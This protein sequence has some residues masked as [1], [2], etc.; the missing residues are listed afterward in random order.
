MSQVSPGD[1]GTRQ[2]PGSPARKGSPAKRPPAK[3]APKG[4]PVPGDGKGRPPTSGKTRNPT[5]G[6]NRPV[7]DQK[8]RPPTG[9]GRPPGSGGGKGRPPGAG[10]AKGRTPRPHM[11]ITAPP[12]RRF[13]P[14]TL[15]FASIGLVVVIILVFVVVKVT[16]G[17]NTPSKTAVLPPPTP[18][19]AQVVSDVTGVTAAVANT[20]GIGSG[21]TAPQ[22][23]KGQP[24]LTD[25]GKPELLFIG[26][27]FCPYCAAERWA[28]VMAMSRFGT[29]SG[30]METTSSPWDVYPDTATFTFRNATF[31]SQY[32][33]LVSVEHET[34]DNN[35]SGTRKLF[36]PL[37][38]A[39]S[40]LW[41]K[42]ST[43]FGE[44]TGYPFLDF[45][46]KVFV[47]GPSYVPDALAGLNQQEIAAKL[48]NTDDVV[49][50]RIVGTANYLTASIC[51]LTGNKPV[52]VCTAPGTHKAAV[53]M[54][55]S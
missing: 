6:Q 22:V 29:W 54:K 50:Q 33:S 46:N 49:T 17:G 51:A 16:S 40:N 21:V 12:P 42:Y 37:T 8:G 24:P 15:A 20:V 2:S 11:Q 23:L 25:G 39:Q 26:A 55:L 3:V 4:G 34:N 19:S 14:S 10:G 7:T 52:A 30:L 45:G 47:L 1:D 18:A 48:S 13:S 38:T 9:G 32:L 35:G 27:E 28:M 44:Q 31:T 5:G 36:Q 43:Q 41:Q 53:S